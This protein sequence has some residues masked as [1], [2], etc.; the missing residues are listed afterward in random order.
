[1][2]V[3]RGPG[4]NTERESRLGPAG[5]DGEAGDGEDRTTGN[6]EKGDLGAGCPLGGATG[7][8][9]PGVLGGSSEPSPSPS[10]AESKTLFYISASL[11][12]SCIQGYRY[13]LSKFSIYA[14][15]YC[16]ENVQFSHSVMS[17][18]V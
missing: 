1:M 5:R 8:L 13:Y 2:G 15:V 16:M 17:D 4:K 14:L 10:P 11:L 12:L 9:L 7:S 18:C 6:V 3:G